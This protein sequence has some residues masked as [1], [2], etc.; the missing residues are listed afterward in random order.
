MTVDRFHNDFKQ[1]SKMS[2]KKHH[3]TKKKKKKKNVHNETN[4]FSKNPK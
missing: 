4:N 3:S 1:D 2:S